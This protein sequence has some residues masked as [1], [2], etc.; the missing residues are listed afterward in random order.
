MNATLALTRRSVLHTVR[1]VETLLMA[2]VLPVM[3]LL[4]FTYV[5]GGAI[6]GST[7]QYLDYVVPGVIVV[8]A[9]FGAAQTAVAV[10]RDM[11]E[12]LMDRFRTI[13]MPRAG[14]VLGHVIASVARN[15]VATA[16]VLM[17][18][19]AL[20]FRPG[21]SLLEWLGV[22]GIVT[23]Y[24][25]AITTLFAAVGIASRSV[26][27]ASGYGFALLFLPYLSSA[28]APV[29]SMPAWLQPFAAHQPLTPVTDALRAYLHGEAAAAQPMLALAWCV[30]LTVVGL[31]F[32]AWAFG[33]R[34]QRR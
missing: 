33:R 6:A 3:L 10:S 9:G 2:I 34:A 25:L 7:G 13:D 28:F 26:E 23:L 15:L 17:V 21:A 12:G 14:V 27:A 31:A 18:A 19:L 4:I 16:V 24:V 20:G 8:C 29:E 32:S 30:G 5:F 11:N 22:L 1:D